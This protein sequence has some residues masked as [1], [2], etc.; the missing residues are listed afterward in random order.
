MRICLM[1]E[2]YGSAIW[3][4]IDLSWKY[5]INCQERMNQEDY[6]SHD[7]TKCAINKVCKTNPKKEKVEG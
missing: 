7:L 1:G 6:S 4:Q 3:G 2:G 5:T